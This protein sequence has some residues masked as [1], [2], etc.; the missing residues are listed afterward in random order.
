MKKA[1][2]FLLLLAQNEPIA[3][4]ALIITDTQVKLSKMPPPGL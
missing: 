3:P 2:E 4:K 1:Q